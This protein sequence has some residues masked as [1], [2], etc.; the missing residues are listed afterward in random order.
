M[1]RLL[2]CVYMK[3]QN[4]I[5]DNKSRIKL[6][7]ELAANQ[8]DAS[9]VLDDP[10]EIAK[11]IADNQQPPNLRNAAIN[12]AKD[13][14]QKG[15]YQQEWHQL[16]KALGPQ[17]E[18]LD[19][20][21]QQLQ[22]RLQRL[23]SRTLFKSERIIQAIEAEMKVNRESKF[24]MTN[25]VQEVY[26]KF[27]SVEKSS[28]ADLIPVP[29]SAKIPPINNANELQT[30]LLAQRN[31]PAFIDAAIKDPAAAIA[32][33][34]NRL[35]PKTEVIADTKQKRNTI[36]AGK[37]GKPLGDLT[38][39]GGNIVAGVTPGS[40]VH[41]ELQLTKIA[42]QQFQK[43]QLVEAEKTLVLAFM[44]KEMTKHVPVT[45]DKPDEVIQGLEK[46]I[47]TQAAAGNAKEVKKAQELIDVIK[48]YRDALQQIQPKASSS[49]NPNLAKGKEE[50]APKRA[51]VGPSWVR[52]EKGETAPQA[53]EPETSTLEEDTTQ[54]KG[55][56]FGV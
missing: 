19:K 39:A 51:T 40:K 6:Y 49:A 53:A 18:S 32:K 29:D 28:K 46:H 5:D 24:R 10:R 50:E 17:V 4:Y 34:E 38:I 56:S 47:I 45:L 52:K 20:R 26:Q 35:N 16:N 15:V 13:L 2:W 8:I 33:L 31:S 36:R 30:F 14:H 27:T 3:I 23:N 41:Q 37:D 9:T 55:Q 12:Y 43:V 21:Y 54:Q 7:T 1:L 11:L 42:L 22:T 48:P 44:D 25:E